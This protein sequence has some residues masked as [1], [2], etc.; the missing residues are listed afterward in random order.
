[1]IELNEGAS[2]HVC[3]FSSASSKGQLNSNLKNFGPESLQLE[4][5]A[6]IL[7]IFGWHFGRNDELIK[8]F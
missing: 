5:R 8:S 7:Q 2:A 3:L 4:G 6:E 1:M